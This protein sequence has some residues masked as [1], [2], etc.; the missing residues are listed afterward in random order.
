MTEVIDR[1]AVE[2]AVPRAESPADAGFPGSRKV[3]VATA[4]R[5]DIRVPFR[6][7]AQSPAQGANGPVTNPVN[8][9]LPDLNLREYATLVPLMLLA[10]W[11]GIYPKPL[12]RV[13]DVPVRQIV[14][15]VNPGYYNSAT[16]QRW[17]EKAPVVA[18]NEPARTK[19]DATRNPFALAPAPVI[20][21]SAAPVAATAAEK[22]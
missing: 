20:A 18:A 5:P 16:A 4:S 21:A 13:L 7:V 12:F 11:I 6:E 3:Y 17:G 14:Q 22:R 19:P 10:F 15:Q 8:E 9:H 2:D 1:T